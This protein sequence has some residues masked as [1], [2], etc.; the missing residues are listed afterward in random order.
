MTASRPAIYLPGL[1]LALDHLM[2]RVWV[3]IL[4]NQEELD[5]YQY[6]GD[7]RQVGCWCRYEGRRERECTTCLMG[8]GCPERGSDR[9]RLTQTKQTWQTATAA[10]RA[11]SPTIFQTQNTSFLFGFCEITC[12]DQASTC[13]HEILS[14]LIRAFNQI[15][16]PISIKTLWLKGW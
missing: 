8:V 16:R 12:Y 10:R 5:G 15:Y 13:I 14:R 2:L 6:S 4:G 9:D 11:I 1:C 3:G 7:S